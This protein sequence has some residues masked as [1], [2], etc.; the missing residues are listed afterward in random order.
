M[1]WI[2]WRVCSLQIFPSYMTPVLIRELELLPDVPVCPSHFLHPFLKVCPSPRCPPPSTG[3]CGTMRSRRSN[4]AFWVLASVCSVRTWG[5]WSASTKRAYRWDN[6]ITHCHT[7]TRS[8]QNQWFF[9]MTVNNLS[10]NMHVIYYIT[11]WLDTT[12]T[13]PDVV[14][15][16]G[17][18]HLSA[19]T[20]LNFSHADPFPLQE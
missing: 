18:W 12:L 1:W 6:R 14:V 17:F 4:R 3:R 8:R 16:C 2:L 5:W 11:H 20:A 9:L 10:L 13:P 7:L 19:V 15:P